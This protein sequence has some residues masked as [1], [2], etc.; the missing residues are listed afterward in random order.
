MTLA[1]ARPFDEEAFDPNTATLDELSAAASREHVHVVTH[2]RDA[3]AHHI[4]LGRILLVAQER[5]NQREWMDWLKTADIS[6]NTAWSAI[7]LATYE[8]A[9][10]KEAFE[11]HVSRAGNQLAPSPSRALQYLKGL[12]AVKG[13]SIHPDAQKAEAKRL[14]AA[15]VPIK[16]IAAMLGIGATTAGVWCD[17]DRRKIELRKNAQRK[18]E[19]RAANAALAQQREVENRRRSARVTGKEVANAYALIR[20]TAAAIDKALVAAEPESRPGLRD[21]LAHCHRC[22]D[23]LVKVMRGKS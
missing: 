14:Y 13:P 17:D 4:R 15:G 1:L 23:Q 18:A 21:A 12:P 6:V 11:P 2:L 10:P 19:K 5:V 9:L 8:S 22:E 20:Q 7:R 16:D 3:L